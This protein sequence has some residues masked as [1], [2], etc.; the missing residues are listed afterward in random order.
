MRT[1]ATKVASKAAGAANQKSWGEPNLFEIFYLFI[2]WNI[3]SEPA[4]GSDHHRPEHNQSARSHPRQNVEIHQDVVTSERELQCIRWNWRD[5]IINLLI[6]LK[7]W[8]NYW[9]LPWT[10]PRGW[11]SRLLCRTGHQWCRPGRTTCQP[12]RRPSQRWWG[13]GPCTCR[14]TPAPSPPPSASRDIREG[15]KHSSS[16]D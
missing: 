7:T 13:T 10:L 11:G 8:R 1:Q 2:V 16:I 4:D 3:L 14:G 12:S 6:I 9:T 15:F 5:F